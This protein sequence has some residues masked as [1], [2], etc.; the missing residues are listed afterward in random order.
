MTLAD[1]RT[2]IGTASTTAAGLV[3]LVTGAEALAGT[4]SSRAV[5][6]AALASVKSLAGTGFYKL[7]VGLIIQ[8]GEIDLILMAMAIKP[9]AGL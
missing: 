5:T 1:L 8:W 4:V 3:E 2:V 7:P 9:L 6:A